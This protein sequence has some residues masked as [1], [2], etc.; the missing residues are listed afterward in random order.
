M[1]LANI[2]FQYIPFAKIYKSTQRG[3]FIETSK[4]TFIK[5]GWGV[6]MVI[7]KRTHSEKNKE[8]EN[9]LCR[10]KENCGATRQSV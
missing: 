2:P 1:L 5:M 3:Y 6:I 7:I 4:L 10:R 9:T 8:K